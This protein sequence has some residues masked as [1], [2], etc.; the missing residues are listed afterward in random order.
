MK[1]MNMIHGIRVSNC[2]L[3]AI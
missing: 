2:G 1:Y 3:I